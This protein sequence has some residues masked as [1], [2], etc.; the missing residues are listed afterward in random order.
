MS[1]I[2]YKTYKV[3]DILVPHQGNAIYTKKAVVSNGWEGDI[4]VISSDTSNNGILCYISKNYVPD[5]DYVDYPCITWTVDGQAGTLTAR[6]IPFV[7]NNHCGYLTPLIDGLYLEYLVLA[8]QPQFYRCAKNSSNKKVGNNQ[9]EKLEV[10]IPVDSHGNPDIDEQRRLSDVYKNINFHKA[11]LLSN[12]EKLRELSIRLPKNEEC[13][14]KDVLPIQLFNPKGGNMSY[15]KT[16]AKAHSGKFPLYSGTTSGSYELVNVADYDGEYLSWCIDGLAG[17][18]MYHNEAFSIT[19]H[20]GVLEPKD[21]VDVSNIDLKYIKYVL[22]P[23]FRKRKKGREG[24]LGKN[25]YTSLKPIAIKKMVD[26][27]PIPVKDDGSFD[28]EKQKELAT[29]YEQIEI[30]KKEL[31]DKINE[32][33]S[34]V[35]S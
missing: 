8:M 4:P 11:K 20:R 15:S 28:L 5:K 22:E 34:I 17:Y 33:T 21:D 27:I 3:T 24:D 31:M 23:I 30:I 14:W 32:L 7:P 13:N 1:E 2:T 18:M 29:K 9:I 16:W 35:V 10:K 12:V 19:C 6:Y 25:E 26:T